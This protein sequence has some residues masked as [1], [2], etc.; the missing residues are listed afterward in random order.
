[1]M[2]EQLY[3]DLNPAVKTFNLLDCLCLTVDDGNHFLYE[4]R[5]MSPGIL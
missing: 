1:M 2:K 3:V 4:I 5:K